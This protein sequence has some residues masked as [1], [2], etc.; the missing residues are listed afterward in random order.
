[1]N[2]RPLYLLIV[3]VLCFS[4]V[5]AEQDTL[6]RCYVGV[7]ILPELSWYKSLTDGVKRKNLFGTFGTG[8]GLGGTHTAI[9]FGLNFLYQIEPRWSVKAMLFINQ[10]GGKMAFRNF[11]ETYF[12]EQENRI[13]VNSIDSS[14]ILSHPDITKYSL[15]ERKYKS[16]YYAVELL[17]RYR[18]TPVKR[19]TS[20][21]LF[22]GPAVYSQ[23]R[24]MAE[25]A[26]AK[27]TPADSNYY[28]GAA[29]ITSDISRDMNETLYAAILGF[30]GDLY[31]NHNFLFSIGWQYYFGVSNVL[32]SSSRYVMNE[33]ESL[34]SLRKGGTAIAFDQN[35]LL[36]GIGIRIGMCYSFGKKITKAL[37]T[38]NGS[39]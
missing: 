18:L 20:F 5:K 33:S 24:T 1:M 36:R 21:N 39:I 13:E 7:N 34:N 37:Q 16:F 3:L 6:K 28:S 19:N 4:Q 29:N 14:F 11:N 32:R 38:S 17:V 26:V 31:I 35:Y 10:N 30:E 27:G 22:I 2:N 25:D 15:I 23:G 8:M 12:V 9:N